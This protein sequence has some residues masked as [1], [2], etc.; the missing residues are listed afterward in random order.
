MSEL[1][2][3]LIGLAALA[4]GFIN[5]IA[6]GGTLISFPALTALGIAPIAA[7]VTNTLALLPG[8]LGGTLAQWKDIRAQARR[9]VVLLPLA[10]VGGLAGGVL[11]LAT[12]ERLFHDL[13]PVLILAASGLLALQGPLRAWLLMRAEKQGQVKVHGMWTTIP[14]FLAAI[15]GGYFGAGLSVILLASLGLGSDESLT[16]LNALKQALAFAVNIAAAI[17]FA[18]SGK[19]VWLAVL[20][21]ALSALAGGWLGGKFAQKIKPSILRW[22][23]VA[24]GT[25]VGVAY[26]VRP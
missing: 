18:F 21:M 11:L 12:G 1:D 19:A 3:A 4:A 8:Y 25:C 20:V 6:G 2:F 17:W 23:V 5:A 13:V 9:F 7:N 22:T 10:L 14:L 15:Y 26:L 24:I 16:K